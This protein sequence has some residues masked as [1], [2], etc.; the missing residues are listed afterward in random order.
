MS[1]KILHIEGCDKF[2]PP[3]IQFVKDNFDF[4]Q[5]KFL[6]RGGMVEKDLLQAL[7]VH[8]AKRSIAAKLNHYL[9]AVIK[10]HQ[11]DKVILH[12]LFDIKLVFLLFLMPWLLRKCYWVMWGGDLYVHK[13]GKRNWKWKIKEVFRRPVIKR[14]GHLV[15]YVKGDVD[16]ARE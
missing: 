2:I 8:F 11:A 12:G 10:M 7:N 5:H 1:N 4:S 9:Q 13:L 15:T 16:L 14:M 3:F 6:L